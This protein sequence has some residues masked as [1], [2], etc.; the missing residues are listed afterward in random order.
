MKEKKFE[1]WFRG[2]NPGNQ[3]RA[4]ACLMRLKK[5]NYS[6]EVYNKEIKRLV[7]RLERKK[8]NTELLK[9]FSGIDIDTLKFKSLV[10]N[11]FDLG[12]KIRGHKPKLVTVKRAGICGGAIGGAC[13]IGIYKRRRI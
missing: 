2:L 1:N 12:R 3:L 10:Y 6:S 8:G 13:G 5:V 4:L 9:F 11:L 7:F